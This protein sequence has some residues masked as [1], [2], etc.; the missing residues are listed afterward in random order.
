MRAL[1]E[2]IAIKCI[3]SL[4]NGQGHL[5]LTTI[6]C[7]AFRNECTRLI[8]I[9]ILKATKKMSIYYTYLKSN[10]SLCIYV[11]V[12]QNIFLHSKTLPDTKMIKQRR[13]LQLYT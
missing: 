1:I 11:I 3:L 5:S 12:Q 2:I 9:Y 6:L 10:C 8:H 4:T 7:L 13:L